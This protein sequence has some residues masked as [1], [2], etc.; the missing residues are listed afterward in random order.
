MLLFPV[1]AI[2]MTLSL[3]IGILQT[4]NGKV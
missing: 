3:L 1:S 2:L 4:L